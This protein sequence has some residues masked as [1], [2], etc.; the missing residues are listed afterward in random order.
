GR[1]LLA[2]LAGSGPQDSWPVFG[3]LPERT[4]GPEAPATHDGAAR[5]SDDQLKTAFE[6]VKRSGAT[7]HVVVYG[8][9]ED[10]PF[11]E[12]RKIAEETGGEF[13]VAASA[14]AVEAACWRISESLQ[15]QYL[16]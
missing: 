16:V 13:M 6:A 12:I 11:P 10:Y 15:H 1:V 3:P 8:G 5:T 14:E 9:A 7:L 4:S 2:L